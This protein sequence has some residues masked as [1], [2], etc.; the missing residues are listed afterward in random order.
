MKRFLAIL[1]MVLLL[2]SVVGCSGTLGTGD[3]GKDGT[4]E[5]P[6]RE[7]ISGKIIEASEFSE[8]F[9]FVVTDA[10]KN[11]T[12]CINKKGEIIF[13][14]NEDISASGITSIYQKFENGLV[15]L[16]SSEKEKSYLCDTK[17]N[18]TYPEDVGATYFSDAAL[19]EGYILAGIT[20][21]TY[22]STKKEL[23]IM[24]MNFQ[25]VVEP[26][27]EL[28]Q[29]V[30][31]SVAIY[32]NDFCGNG[33]AYAEHSETYLEL[34]TGKVYKQKP[35]DYKV[36]PEHWNLWTDKTFRDPEEK[37]MLDLA[38]HENLDLISNF[39]DGKAV[40][41]FYNRKAGK[42]FMTVIDEAGVFEYEPIELK[43]NFTVT[44]VETDG[45]YILVVGYG[46]GAAC[47]D[48]QGNLI[49]SYD[50]REDTER[51]KFEL[52]DGVI[53]KSRRSIYK[54]SSRF[55]YLNPDFT[56]LF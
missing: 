27:E 44:D 38:E 16:Y 33:F 34:S 40:L 23:G 45:E 32:N 55:W 30:S 46:I 31:F 18:I 56:P 12:H 21:A 9:A 14:V 25:W 26:S 39:A 19:A 4:K 10:N 51:Y 35:A 13:S 28:E 7:K 47:F 24:D 42:N 2:L 15:C 5:E 8:G 3:G 50:A 53:L 22:E 20:T 37:V 17:G 11:V 6:A 1:V 43:I 48:M 49:G 54:D 41:I 36:Q 29:A 52:S